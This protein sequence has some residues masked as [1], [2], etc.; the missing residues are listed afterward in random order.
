VFAAV[1][2][3]VWAAAGAWLGWSYDK[4]EE[5]EKVAMQGNH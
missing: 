2:A 1:V 3:A 4:A 5:Q